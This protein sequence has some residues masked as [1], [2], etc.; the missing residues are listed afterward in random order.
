MMLVA[1][2]LHQ[3]ATHDLPRDATVAMGKAMA[4]IMKAK[5]VTP[6]ISAVTGLPKRIRQD[7]GAK[8]AKKAAKMTKETWRKYQTAEY[9]EAWPKPEYMQEKIEAKA[10]RDGGQGAYRDRTYEIVT[11]W[12]QDTKIEYRPHA[13]APGSKSH[14]RYEKYSKAKTIGQALKL[15]SYPIDWCFDYEHGFIKVVGGDIRDEPIDKSMVDDDSQLTAVDKAIMNWYM[16][17]LAKR[18][19]LR[20]ADLRIERGAME[21]MHM[22]AHRL[23]A[24]RT[25]QEILKRK[26]NGRITADDVETV[27]TNW[28]FGRNT[29]R[30]N[31]MPQGQEWVKSDTLGLLRDRGGNIHVTKPTKRYPS[32]STLLNKFL[33][34]RL[35]EEAAT[36]KWTSLNLNCN[37]AARRHRD[38]NNFGPSFIQAFGKFTG[39]TL[40]VWPEDNKQE[41]K[42]HQLPE[43]M[44]QTVDIK[45]NLVLFNGN[46]A[47][48]VNDFEGTRFSVVYF[49]CV[50]LHL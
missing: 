26:K 49:C 3:A 38:A 34:Q 29:S 45:K 21:S 47:H 10:V 22:R 4:N 7:R 1:S 40:S 33:I 28:S 48:E 14:I 16:R 46:T 8:A 30:Q 43:K 19:G 32:I 20:V 2:I 31:V 50:S 24:E 17:E 12:T 27:L 15:G 41:G 6:E 9:H 35:P 23:V 37:Y 44:K 36:F 11:R 18:C 42:P 39:G 25:A 5:R 13:K